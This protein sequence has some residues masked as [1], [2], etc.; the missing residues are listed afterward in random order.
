VDCFGDHRN[1]DEPEW[2]VAEITTGRWHSLASVPR[3]ALKDEGPALLYLVRPFRIG[4]SYL[5]DLPC[6][7][8]GSI[9]WRALIDFNTTIALVNDGA[10]LLTGFGRC[11]ESA[12][13]QTQL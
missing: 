7:N 13:G 4:V 8:R 6:G 1:E 3:K 5:D 9:P 12:H 10:L 11:A 2:I